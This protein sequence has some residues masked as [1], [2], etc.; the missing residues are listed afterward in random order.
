MDVALSQTDEIL[1]LCPW[2]VRSWDSMTHGMQLA[3]SLRNMGMA[4][5]L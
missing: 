2:N 3:L 1:A 5:Y 4:P